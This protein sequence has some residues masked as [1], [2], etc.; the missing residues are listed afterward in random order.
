MYGRLYINRNVADFVHLFQFWSIDRPGNRSGGAPNYT[1]IL[2]FLGV[3]VEGKEC[4]ED[5]FSQTRVIWEG[6]RLDWK[7]WLVPFYKEHRPVWRATFVCSKTNNDIVESRMDF[8]ADGPLWLIKTGVWKIL[9]CNN[10]PERRESTIHDRNGPISLCTLVSNYLQFIRS[11]VWRIIR[12]FINL[13]Y[14]KS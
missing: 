5:L 2:L 14:N 13:R 7:I 1:D 4:V 6:H 12:Q 8:P 10:V 9:L 11:I 3:H